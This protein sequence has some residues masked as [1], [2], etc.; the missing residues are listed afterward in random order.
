MDSANEFIGKL[1]PLYDGTIQGR[2]RDALLRSIEWIGVS[3]TRQYRD[4]QVVDLCTAL[5]AVLTTIDDGRKGEAIALRSMLLSVALDRPFTD[6]QEV[7]ILYELR[8]RIVHGADLGV[9]GE[10]DYIK[11]RSLAERVLM[12]VLE[13]YEVS[14]PFRRPIELIRCL[15]DRERLE[16]AL[17]WLDNWQDAATKAVAK[18]CRKKT[19]IEQ[20]DNMRRCMENTDRAIA[21]RFPGS[22]SQCWIHAQT[23]P[24]S[25][26]SFF[27]TNLTSKN[28]EKDRRD[29]TRDV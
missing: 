22:T 10:N 18:Y 28:G 12:G 24:S 13:L 23:K 16:Q 2:F 4:H 9:C 3:I 15:E 7:Y 11:L 6:P 20:S 29:F 19:R 21:V 25:T 5:E 26:V 1:A 14:G 27:A 8:S 17:A